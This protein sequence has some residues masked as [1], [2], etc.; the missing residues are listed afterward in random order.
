MTMTKYDTALHNFCN[1]LHIWFQQKKIRIKWFV[2]GLMRP[3]FR[4]MAPQMKAFPSYST[5]RLWL[6]VRDERDGNFCII[7]K[8]DYK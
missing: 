6:D 2:E 7:M 1:I 4:A 5:K 8:N 3:L